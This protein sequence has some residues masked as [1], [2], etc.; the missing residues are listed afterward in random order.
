MLNPTNQNKV[1]VLLPNST[2]PR[3][4]TAFAAGN[5]PQQAVFSLNYSGPGTLDPAF[6]PEINMDY[7]GSFKVPYTSDGSESLSTRGANAFCLN[8]TKTGFFM[9]KDRA[10]AEWT[11]PTPAIAQDHHAL[12]SATRIQNFFPVFAN[13]PNVTNTF[14]SPR[15]GWLK[16]VN[17]KLFGSMY[18]YYDADNINR[19]NVFVIDGYEDLSTCTVYGFMSLDQASYHDSAAR[20]CFDI[21]ASK[22][23]A[24]GGYH[25]AAGVTP[26]LAIVGRSS[27]GHTFQGIAL[28]QVL[29]TDT[30]I[31]NTR[32]AQHT[33]T[34]PVEGYSNYNALVANHYGE[35]LGLP[36]P[37]AESDWDAFL[38]IDP[39]QRVNTFD[40]LPRPADN[41]YQTKLNYMV[42]CGVGFIP[43]GSNSVVYVGHLGGAEFG[44]TYKNHTLEYGQNGQEAGGP[45]P[46]SARDWRNIVWTMNLD[47]IANAQ[48]TYDPA[49]SRVI[50][51]DD[52][53]LNV[54]SRSTP[55][56]QVI[57]G[58]YDP[59]SGKLYLLHSEMLDNAVHPFNTQHV[60]SVWNIG[61]N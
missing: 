30:T 28:D 24:L 7:I 38:K 46:I 22:R 2:A 9:G 43:A 11:M 3:F 8:E 56:G 17:G 23:A 60:V 42:G 47:D 36:N 49:Y 34:N 44:G 5:R 12:P 19:D 45:W 39:S 27:V 16:I 21:P 14:P 1:G 53:H 57:S 20:Y 26:E 54:M 25:F 32:Y 50:E 55:R 31:T 40:G 33:V 35:L 51:L 13:T 52:P 4:D 15:L 10:I 41:L 37:T 29:V 58:D 6:D 48:N 61:V 59:V 18:E